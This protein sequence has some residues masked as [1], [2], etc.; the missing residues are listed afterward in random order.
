MN[1]QPLK[2][3]EKRLFIRNFLKSFTDLDYFN[4]FYET[5]P[6]IQIRYAIRLKDLKNKGTTVGKGDYFLSTSI[7]EENKFENFYKN[8]NL[9][10]KYKIVEYPHWDKENNE[11]ILCLQSEPEKTQNGKIKIPLKNNLIK[12]YC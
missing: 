4:E 12:N 1:L 9:K 11:I 5:L 6:K 3:K 10:E 7:F 8:G 2:I